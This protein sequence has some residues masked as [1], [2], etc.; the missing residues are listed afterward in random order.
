M[1]YD[2]KRGGSH[3][4][5][6]TALLESWPVFIW[7][8]KMRWQTYQ[9]GQIVILCLGALATLLIIYNPAGASK[10]FGGSETR[11]VEKIRSGRIVGYM[12][13]TET[14]VIRYDS[15]WNVQWLCN[16]GEDNLCP[17]IN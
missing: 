16:E 5:N 14:Q 3:F 10:F 12:C 7:Q 11:C 4:E 9:T 2:E 8:I 17:F 13:H 6:K 1:C 15:K